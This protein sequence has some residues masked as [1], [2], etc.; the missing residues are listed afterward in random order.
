M[1]LLY[2]KQT[3]GSKG[4]RKDVIS[5][6]NTIIAIRRDMIKRLSVN[7]ETCYAGLGIDNERNLF[8]FLLKNIIRNFL[9]LQNQIIKLILFMLEFRIILNQQ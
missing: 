8:F 4:I 3:Q 5:V 2:E 1:N 6:S 9:K 7:S